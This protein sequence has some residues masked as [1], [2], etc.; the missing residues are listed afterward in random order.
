[1]SVSLYPLA[2]EPDE[3][4]AIWGGTSLVARYGKHAAPAAKIGESWECYDGNTVR[5]G[6]YAG[7]TIGELRARLGADLMGGADPA[8]PF[9][10]LTKLIDARAALSVQVH[11]DDAYARRV[12]GAPNGKTECWCV[13]EADPGAE[14]V[15]GWNRA[16]TR[17]EY[18]ERVREASLDDVLRRVPARPGDAFYLPAGTLH[19]I[20]AG[21]VLFETQQTSDLTYRIYDYD[22]RGADGKPRELHVD[23]AADVLDYRQSHAGALHPLSYELDGLRR[24]TLV[25]DRNFIVE[26][27]ALP[28]E[29][30]GIDLDGMPLVVQALGDSVELEA[31]GQTL[32]LEPYQSAVV[33]AALDVVMVRAAGA[34]GSAAGASML[35]A[36]PPRDSSALERRFGRAG[37]SQTAAADFL[38]QF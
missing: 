2:I 15:L 29:R 3:R 33:P 20:G 18:L 4:E 35:V 1:V 38:V 11:P 8:A 28:A 17:E 13:L 27:I 19:A 25:A 5:N 14:I 12:E 36:A 26:R 22:R 7:T 31:R 10:L 6:S 16:T 37:V 21:I 9:P 32:Y 30:R 34:D 24:T 23:K